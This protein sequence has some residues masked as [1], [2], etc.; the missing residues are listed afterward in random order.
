MFYI[1]LKSLAVLVFITQ[2]FAGEW[3]VQPTVAL[4]APSSSLIVYR[5]MHGKV[6]YKDGSSFG[7][8]AGR[9]VG[10]FRL[11]VSYDYTSF[12][13][14]E[15]TLQTPYG[16]VSQKDNDLYRAHAVLANIAWEPRLPLS[17]LNGI[18]MAGAGQSFN[19]SR[20]FAY[21]LGAGIGRQYGDWEAKIIFSKRVVEGEQKYGH[22]SDGSYSIVVQ[23][24][25]QSR[26]TISLGRSF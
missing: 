4:V 13:A 25:S 16:E 23:E 17:R 8:Q 5:G 15:V 21:Q 2:A 22:K 18:L 6:D 10:A 11:Y 3:F 7:L 19:G 26:L 12:R 9:N 1:P 24:P 20:N 14:K